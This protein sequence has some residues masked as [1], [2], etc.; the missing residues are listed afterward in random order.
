MQH[1][2]LY[3]L[4]SHTCSYHCT[5]KCLIIIFR[6][7]PLAE[8]LAVLSYARLEASKRA[9]GLQHPQ[10]CLDAIQF[11]VEH[12]GAAGLEKVCDKATHPP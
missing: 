5:A 10:L 7:E 8:A 12:G 2:F 11:G 3:I 6:L 4:K 9:P 1:S